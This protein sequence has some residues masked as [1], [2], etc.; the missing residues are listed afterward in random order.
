[1][2]HSGT[3]FAPLPPIIPLRPRQRPYTKTGSRRPSKGM[4]RILFLCGGSGQGGDNIRN[5]PFAPAPCRPALEG[6][7]PSLRPLALC[8]NKEGRNG[9]CALDGGRFAADGRKRREARHGISPGDDKI[10]APICPLRGIYAAAPKPAGF[11][12]PLGRAPERAAP[13]RLAWAGPSTGRTSRYSGRSGP[14]R[15]GW[16]PPGP[17]ASASCRRWC[18]AGSCGPPP[19]G[20]GNPASGR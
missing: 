5:A 15:R 9:P 3:N 19:P 14:P 4:G 8:Q 18:P 10:A 16:P 13:W 6:G 2:G 20:P 1:M 12:C 11:E 7:S 17:C